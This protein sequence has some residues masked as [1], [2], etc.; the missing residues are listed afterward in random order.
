[1]ANTVTYDIVSKPDWVTI[2]SYGPDSMTISVSDS[3]TSREGLIELRQSVS[4][5]IER[6]KI[7]QGTGGGQTNTVDDA[8]NDDYMFCLVY[9]LDKL[10]NFQVGKSNVYAYRHSNISTLYAAVNTTRA[11][12]YNFSLEE[13]AIS[14]LTDGSGGVK[15][16]TPSDNNILNI[17]GNRKVLLFAKSK[18]ASVVPNEVEYYNSHIEQ[19][20]IPNGFTEIAN[21]SLY[22]CSRL[23][24][25]YISSSITK[26]TSDCFA[27][28]PS[29]NNIYISANSAPELHNDGSAGYTFVDTTNKTANNSGV[30]IYVKENSLSSYK[31]DS[32][33][34]WKWDGCLK[35]DLSSYT[36]LCTPL[37]SWQIKESSL[38]N[39]ELACKKHILFGI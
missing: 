8:L 15:Y 19:T 27:G 30:T 13:V 12:N 11:S 25:I 24:D 16:F 2:D 17:N 18:T 29:L 5:F 31:E 32:T 39:D 6:I 22:N 34:I 33:N 3:D 38:L 36:S 9:N 37:H 35:V 23:T 28:L 7:Q 20:I 14:G 10:T 1:M 21:A 26:F 4:G